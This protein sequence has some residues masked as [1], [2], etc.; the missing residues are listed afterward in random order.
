MQ[1]D[2]VPK[3]VVSV[4]VSAYFQKHNQAIVSFCRPQAKDAGHRCN[5]NDVIA[6][7]ERPSGRVA[8][9][10]NLV[11]NLGVFFDEGVGGGHVRFWL[12]IIVVGNEVLN[13]VIREKLLEFGIQLR[14]QG[15]VWGHYQGWRPNFGNHVCDGE[16][17]ARTSNPQQ[18]LVSDIG[19]KAIDKGLYRGRLVS[20]RLKITLQAKHF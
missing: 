7:E 14:G 19:F 2:Q 17:L 3:Q 10:V 13:S 11:V 12:V 9:P 5:D 18:D 8:H 15:F 1:F 20:G 4:N 6:F 16:S